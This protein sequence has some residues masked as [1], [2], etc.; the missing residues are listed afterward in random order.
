MKKEIIFMLLIAAM[1]IIAG[2]SMAL[3]Q[4]NDSDNL[5]TNETENGNQVPENETAIAKNWT[6]DC[7]KINEVV[8]KKLELFN[9]GHVRRINAYNNT[10][11]MVQKLINNLGD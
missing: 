5:T 8:S 10:E 2:I 9:E 1:L 3:A 11:V 4:E 6:K 7:D